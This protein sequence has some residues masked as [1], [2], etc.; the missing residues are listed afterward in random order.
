MRIQ[1]VMRLVGQLMLIV[2]LTML[3]PFIYGIMFEE[4]F[5]SFLFSTLVAAAAGGLLFYFGENS[6]SYSLRDGF[7]T[8]GSTWILVSVFA[9]LPFYFGGILPNFIDALFESISGITATGASVIPDIDTIPEAYVL[10]RSLTN[11][12]GGMGIIVL[13]LAFLKNLGAD[14]AHL[15]NAEASVPRPGVVMPRIRSTALKLWKIYLLFSAICFVALMLAGMSTFDAVNMTFSIIAT[16]GY[17]PNTGVAD[18]YANNGYIRFILV[19]FMILAGGNFTVYYNVFQQGLQ[20]VWQD[21]EYRMY[22]FILAVGALFVVLSLCLQSELSVWESI[23]VGSFMLVSMQTGSGLSLG[24]YDQW[25]PLGQMML[26][27]ATFFGGC[28]GSTTGGIKI[29]RIIIL[30]KSSLIYLRKAIHPDLVQSIT[31]NKKP[32]PNKWVQLAQEFFFLYLTIFAISALCISAT[33]LPFGESIQC[34]A[35]ILGN[36]GLGFG[37][38]GPSGS[39][40][41]LHPFAKIVCLIDMLLGRLEL[42]TLLVLLHPDFWQGYFVKRRKKSYKIWQPVR[43]HRRF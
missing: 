41:V 38:L 28:S 12:L 32:M 30:I 6:T 7:L 26:F 15:F 17:T 40:A 20:S 4:I 19:T 5:F 39:F 42:F 36:V 24:N 11:W 10:W 23:N 9:A 35:G 1:I 21:F 27:M 13:V 37:T 8:V 33:G 18:I 29:I 43:A 2:S 16:G 3:I 34:V 31:I 22:I 25:P 14:S